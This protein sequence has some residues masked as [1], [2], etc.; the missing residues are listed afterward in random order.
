MGQQDQREI[1]DPEPAQAAVDGADVGTGVDEHGLTGRGGEDQRIPLTDVA[2]HQ[3]RAWRRPAPH[4]L[5]DGPAHDDE[6]DH[7]RQ[8]QQPSAPA[9]PEQRRQHEKQPG[10]Q[11]RST[12]TA[13]PRRHSV[14]DG[15]AAVR[16]GHQPPDR[17]PR[18][19]DEHVG[20]PREEGR[21]QTAE[22]P[23][24]GRRRDG[25]RR[26]EVGGQGDQADLSRERGD[27]RCRRQPR[28]RAH[29]EG[30]GQEARAA[31]PAQ[32]PRPRRRQQHDRR[33]GGHGQRE[34][35][36]GGEVRVGEQQ[37]GDRGAECRH[38]AS[39][40]PRRQGRK[41]DRAHR[42]GPQH[43][44]LRTGQ[45]DEAHQREHADQCLHPAVD[46]PT[47]QRPEDAGENHGDVRP[48]H[49]DEMGQ[50]GG[51][52][53]LLDAAVQGPGVPHDQPRQ[54][55][56]LLRWKNPPGGRR[57]PVPHGLGCPLRP[58]GT[59]LRRRRSARRE[60]RRDVVA[61]S[62]RR[63]GAAD[64]RPLPREQSRP[65]VRGREDQHV[66]VQ[67]D[68]PAAVVEGADGGLHQDAWSAHPRDGSRIGVQL[69]LD[70]DAAARPGQRGQ[71]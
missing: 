29:R 22:E 49:R 44:G 33:R 65:S 61:R 35:G 42:R 18:R 59:T 20:G 8:R 28:G 6:A 38:G 43:A 47:A 50:A 51:P 16:D 53:V 56:R 5:A 68:P 10:H 46:R 60:H 2:G 27:E 52:E 63:D 17:P 23:E 4:D 69:H 57:E 48:G 40:S 1:V 26:E 24:H 19:P 37:H 11:Q 71:W 21:Q 70:D 58:P 15:G 14:R 66:V 25:R 7:C 32:A 36:V 30:I 12:G 55:T 67:G 54:E 3:V 9:P 39:R 41:R 45:H 31:P 13:R 64:P 62:R 34:T